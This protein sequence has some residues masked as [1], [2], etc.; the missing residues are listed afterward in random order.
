MIQLSTWTGGTTIRTSPSLPFSTAFAQRLLLATS[1]RPFR[2]S[3][4]KR[5]DGKIR[6]MFAFIPKLEKEERKKPDSFYQEHKLFPVMDLEKNSWRTI[7]LDGVFSFEIVF[8]NIFS[9]ERKE[10]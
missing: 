3:F 8:P 2:V 9:S 6:H 7:P 1:H 5:T 4:T 10:S